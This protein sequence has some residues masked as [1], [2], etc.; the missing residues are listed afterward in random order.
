MYR[1]TLS[2][3]D[4]NDLFHQIEAEVVRRNVHYQSNERSEGCHRVEAQVPMKS[5]TQ[6]GRILPHYSWTR[7]TPRTKRQLMP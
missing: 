1:K 5:N 3:K 4:I 2:P 6:P 7:R